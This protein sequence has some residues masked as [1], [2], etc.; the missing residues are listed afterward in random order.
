[1]RLTTFTD[2]SLRVLIYLAGAA[3]HRATIAEIAG[4]FGIS[5]NHLV[6]VVH[7]LGKE[8]LLINTRGHG[9]GVRLARPPTAINIAR[10]VRLTEGADV[11]AE[12]FDRET[13]RCALTAVCR[14]QP[15][16]KEGVTAFY[17]ALGRYSLEDLRIPPAK[18]ARAITMHS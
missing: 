2:Y 3:E 16:L 9:G 10:V 6:K 14:L 13:N 5:E 17:E 4:A 12:C 1:V 11:P 18:L 15:V 8:G 7:L